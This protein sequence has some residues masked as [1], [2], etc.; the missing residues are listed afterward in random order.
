MK[1]DWSLR[2]IAWGS[3]QCRADR[4][5]I[6]DSTSSPCDRFT[7]SWGLKELNVLHLCVISRIGLL[8]LTLVICSSLHTVSPLIAVFGHLSVGS[9]WTYGRMASWW[10][11][12]AII[13]LEGLIVDVTR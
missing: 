13:C 4:R 1:L 6:T 7:V 10:Q 3:M 5:H 12:S 9:T 11:L 2:H 8:Y